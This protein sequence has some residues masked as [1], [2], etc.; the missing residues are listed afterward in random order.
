MQIPFVDLKA[1]YQSIKA[2]IDATI[3]EVISNT[4]FVGGPYVES[5]ERAFA[6]FCGVKHC[7]GVGNGTDAIFIALRALGIGKGDEVI[8]A[9]NSFIATSEAITMTGARVAFV[10]IDPATYN[11]DPEKLAEF[12]EQNCHHT[13]STDYPIDKSTGLP[14][15]AVIPVH[16]YGQPA[17]MD[18][19]LETASRHG[20]KVVEDAAQAH[21][22]LYKG[23]KIGSLGD[24]AC[25]SFYPGKNL[26]AYGDGGAIV[27][28]NDDLAQKARM[29]SNH[30]RI[31]KYD[32]EFEGVNSRLDG[33]QAAIL[34]VK[35]RYLDQ[36]NES[37]RRTAGL[38][39]KNLGGTSLIPPREKDGAGSVY[40][41]YVVRADAERRAPL[42]E[43][44]KAKGVSTGIHYPVALPY[45]K[46][47]AYVNPGPDD[48]PAA[49]RASG[50][51]LSLP[52]YPELDESQV[53]YVAKAVK[54][55]FGRS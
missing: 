11:M 19:I 25:F 34:E 33:M 8:T 20:L 36:W 13:Q 1:Q 4:A 22:A 26:G 24:V 49:K 47:Y 14:V 43:F 55:F 48:F 54:E 21:G 51:V 30:G 29:I 16:L 7:L 3:A 31:G 40:H 6:E 35:L 18:P 27:T 2:E 38:Y 9:A 45:L 23:R 53:T 41:L 5:F 44:L 12:L 52:I 10:D 46:A 17:D 32:H 50:E 39:S 37:R 28:N 42:Q 15:K